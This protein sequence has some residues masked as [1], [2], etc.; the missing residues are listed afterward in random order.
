MICFKIL[1]TI[2]V[3]VSVQEEVVAEFRGSSGFM[4][5]NPWLSNYMY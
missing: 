3:C 1:V 5:V 4:L 2:R